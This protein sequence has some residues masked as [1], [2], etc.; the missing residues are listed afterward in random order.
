MLGVVLFPGF[1]PSFRFLGCR[2]DCGPAV[3]F[4]GG[5]QGIPMVLFFSDQVPMEFHPAAAY[6][7][8][9]P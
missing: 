5:Y 7:G 6:G 2:P 8:R 4:W 1:F 9:T 3:I